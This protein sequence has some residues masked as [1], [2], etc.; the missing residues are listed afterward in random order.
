VRAVL[1][2]I[3]PADD[4]LPAVTTVS[5][6]E[7]LQAI[8]RGEP[9]IHEE[10][11]NFLVEGLMLHVW[12]SVRGIVPECIDCYLHPV[13]NPHRRKRLTSAIFTQ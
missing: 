13:H 11:R 9:S 6:I 4:G 3:I 7:Y 12:R 10:I 2:L 5:G 1:D 8:G